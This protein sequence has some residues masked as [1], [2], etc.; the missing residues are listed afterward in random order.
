MSTFIESHPIVVSSI[1]SITTIFAISHCM[2]RS[3][4]ICYSITIFTIIVSLLTI[5]TMINPYAY[6]STTSISCLYIILS[7]Y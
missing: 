1:S 4:I 5:P 3:P 2:I 6:S 7:S